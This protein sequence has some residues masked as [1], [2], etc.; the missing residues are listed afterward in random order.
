[1]KTNLPKIINL[2][3]TEIC[4][5]QCIMCN[6][7]TAGKTDQFTCDDIENIFKQ[8]YFQ[9]VQH[10]GIS[11]GEP[12]L[13]PHLFDI[14]QTLIS[15]VPGLKTLSLTSHGYHT[16]KHSALLPNIKKICEQNGISFS[17][18]LSLDGIEDIHNKVRRTPDA[19]KKVTA[20]ARL[21]KSLGI[22]VQFQCTISPINLYNIVKV[23]E[24]AL[25]NNFEV[26]F[27]VSTYIARLS[28]KN[29]AERIKLN[30]KQRSFVADFIESQ[31]TVKATKSL[32]RRLFYKDLAKRL[33]EDT[34]RSAPC[35]FQSN[36]LFISPDKSLYNCSRSEQK[37]KITSIN[38][39]GA[40]IN[41]STNKAILKD[42]VNNT[43]HSC[44]HDQSGRWPIL[45]YLTV[46]DKFKPS[47][48]LLKKILSIPN[49][50]VNFLLPINSNI[51]EVN[52]DL[53]K[54]LIIGSYG[55]EHV[56]DAAILG[57]VILR[58][59]KKYNSNTF[60]IIS[61][62]PDRTT[63]WVK[64]LNI[65]KVSINV[66]STSSKPIIANYNALVLAGGPIMSIP[67]LLTNHIKLVRRFKKEQKPFIIEGVGIGPLYDK[68]S[69]K[70]A[71]KIL[72]TANTISVRTEKDFNTLKNISITSVKTL[73]PAF[74]YI[75]YLNLDG[76][77][78]D[79][80][81]DN[82][83]NTKKDIWVINIRPL[84]KKYSKSKIDL[85]YIENQIIETIALTL[86]K[87]ENGKRFIFMPM[88]TDQFG[89]S[90]LE[91]AYKLE[92]KLLEKSKEIDFK[93]WEYET[94]INNCIYLLKKSKL[95][96]SMRFHGCI[97]SLANNTP[98]I[99]LDYSTSDKGKVYSLFRDLKIQNNVL[100]I[101]NLN[102][103]S[104]IQK[105][106]NLLDNQSA[107][108]E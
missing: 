48:Q 10:I 59:I 108:Y 73:D 37:L 61:I 68:I 86:Y 99:G 28:N 71:Q 96:I 70:L 42:L 12:T 29:L 54:I 21:A 45:H 18:N 76:F 87:F 11:G 20:T 90:D 44:Y 40:S 81:L 33:K 100:N 35:S 1:M 14:C 80:Y 7:W 31:R 78:P 106:N 34:S 65:P 72:K 93:I 13:N 85:D 63:S 2:P 30:E 38:N 32:G 53:K 89:F 3:I 69:K 36:A 97:F 15:V 50:L 84:W 107:N 101:M 16:D 4:D 92:K 41:N 58:L 49:V 77:N 23:R 55:G 5:S 24:F 74:D 94:D 43:C 57:G 22:H 67:L 27:R 17:L 104:L 46:H 95:T 39:I 62:R 25:E 83:L 47:I 105:I 66:L 64:N 26:I 88:N 91:I 79:K 102:E 8:K 56:G 103:K 19:F 52:S 98:T 6:V 9:K 51:N 60:D 75:N 82:L